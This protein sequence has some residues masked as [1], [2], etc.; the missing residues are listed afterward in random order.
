MFTGI[1]E[2]VGTVVES[3]DYGL[4]VRADKVM[5]GL[6]L[7][8]SMAVNGTCLTVVEFGD[9][10]FQVDLAPG[11]CAAPHWVNWKPAAG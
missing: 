5:D 7:G 3:Q 4:T 2:E 1:V 6:K 10:Q 11:H 9:R 8:D